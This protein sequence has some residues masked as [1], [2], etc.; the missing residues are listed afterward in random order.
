MTD[1][2]RDHPRLA[3]VTPNSAPGLNPDRWRR[4]RV[5]RPTMVG[6]HSVAPFTIGQASVGPVRL[7]PTFVYPVELD[8]LRE[9]ALADG[10]STAQLPVRKDLKPAPAADR[11]DHLDRT[12]HPDGVRDLRLPRPRPT[13]PKPASR[14][15]LYSVAADVCRRRDVHDGDQDRVC[16]RRSVHRL[17]LAGRQRAR[18]QH[19]YRRERESPSSSASAAIADWRSLPRA[20]AGLED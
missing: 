4:S 6:R 7:S 16:H 10:T 2:Q 8:E 20:P 13:L 1:G 18:D 15:A 5:T 19:R 12:R 17:L 11:D 14:Q 3:G 9:G